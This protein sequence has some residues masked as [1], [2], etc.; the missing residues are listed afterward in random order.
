M[1]ITKNKR[2]SMTYK[3]KLFYVITALCCISSLI[4]VNYNASFYERPIAKVTKTALEH[5]SDVQDM[6]KNKDKIFNQT[7]TAKLENGSQKG[8]LIHLSNQYSS[9]GANDQKY[10]PGDEVFV[11]IDKGKTSSKDISGSIIDKKRDKQLLLIAWIFIFTLLIVGKK[12]GFF[13]IIS[14]MF[15]AVLLSYALDL[16]RKHP[17]IGL[18]FIC[19]ICILI[20]TVISLLLVSGFHEKTYAAIAA[21]LA[22]TFVSLLIT[23]LVMAATG[24]KGLRYEE[25]QYLTRPY[26]TV[27][28]AGVFIGSLGAVMDVAITMTSSVFGLYEENKSISLQ[29][30]KRSGMEI[31]KDIMGAMTNILFFAYISGSIPM[32]LLYLKNDSPIGFTLSMNISLEIARALAGGIGIVLTIPASLYASVFFIKRKKASS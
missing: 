28:M 4:F 12:Q 22:G 3:I 17:N 30:L 25:M 18:I 13:S 11:S 9:S 31:G 14:L 23:Y 26:H 19:G 2:N 32:M 16:Y 10:Q 20:F 1:K 24:E 29:A 6:H 27:F 7:I 8:K 5:Q 15:N 21:T